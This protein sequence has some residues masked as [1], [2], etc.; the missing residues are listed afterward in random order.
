MH[1]LAE[2]QRELFC[3]AGLLRE[4][5]GLQP[6]SPAHSEPVLPGGLQQLDHLHR[7]AQLRDGGQGVRDVLAVLV[8][9]AIEL[10]EA[11]GRSL[12]HSVGVGAEKGLHCQMLP[13][14]SYPEAFASAQAGR[15]QECCLGSLPSPPCG[16]HLIV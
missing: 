5:L 1:Q 3:R 6:A 9:V 11:Q 8:A 12:G 16:H 13:L 15:E 4:N 14:L 10:G 2:G 7:G